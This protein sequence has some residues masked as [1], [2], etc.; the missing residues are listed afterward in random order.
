MEVYGLS[1]AS[2]ENTYREGVQYS[3]TA[4]V[5]ELSTISNNKCCWLGSEIQCPYN[6]FDNPRFDCVTESACK[7]PCVNQAN[8]YGP[9]QASQQ[10]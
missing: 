4:T 7:L 5:L 3:S 2:L 1:R 10:R 6:L 8:A 9:C